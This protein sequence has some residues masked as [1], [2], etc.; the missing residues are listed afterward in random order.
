MLLAVAGLDKESLNERTEALASRDWSSFLPADR[1]AFLFARKQA[2]TP[3]AITAADTRG[4]VEHF[5]PQRALDVL[6]WTC[7][8]HYM[9]RVA[10][11]FQL[12]LER[13]NVF[14]EP[15][16]RHDEPR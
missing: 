8:C 12:P 1:F 7:R 9:T 4:L 11:A 3:W 14:E 5:G 10:D 16:A 6:W 2:K 15:I 13:E